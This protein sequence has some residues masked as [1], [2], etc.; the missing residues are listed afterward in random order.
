M[1]LF[2]TDIK[3]FTWGMHRSP[4]QWSASKDFDPFLFLKSTSERATGALYIPFGAGSRICIGQH[5]A[6]LELKIA[7]AL[8]LRQFTF[9]KA[10]ETAD[11][12][13]ATDWQHAAVH[14]DKDMLF[15]LESR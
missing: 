5:L 7:A 6:M 11:L 10:P 9:S 3:A 12:V 14:P 4:T 1:I 2:Q 13:F 8:L 15:T